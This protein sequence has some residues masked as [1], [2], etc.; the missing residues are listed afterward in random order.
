[1]LHVDSTEMVTYKEFLGEVDSPAKAS[2]HAISDPTTPT[3]M[4]EHTSD[5]STEPNASNAVARPPPMAVPGQARRII[6]STLVL[7]SN[8][9]QM[10]VFFAG[11]AG[12]FRLGKIFGVSTATSAWIAASYGLTQGAFVLVSGP[13]GSVYGHKNMVVWGILILGICSLVCG[14]ANNFIAFVIMRAL[15]GIGGGMIMPNAVA[16]ITIANPPGPTRNVLLGIFGATA[17]LGGVFGALLLGLFMQ[18][19]QYKWFFLMVFLLS[20]VLALS[21]IYLIPK[22]VP[23]N[24]K[25]KID[26]TGAAMITSVLMLFNFSWNQAPSSGWQHPAV[27]TT[28]VLSIVLLATFLAWERW[29][30]KNPIMP[31]SIFKA[32]SFGLLVLV[33]LMNFMAVGIFG[34]YQVL[35]LQEVWNWSLLHFGKLSKL[36]CPQSLTRSQL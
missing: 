9:L 16:L 25:D 34:W 7:F 35:W 24:R 32:P 22:E 3:A 31:L 14:F 23:V 5:G 21:L 30:A 11:T 1:M 2:E 20:L 15:S 10:I 28:L 27:I 26:W 19:T 36:P 4:S 17:P 13:I 18:Y 33:V 6:M 8:I 12:G 29:V